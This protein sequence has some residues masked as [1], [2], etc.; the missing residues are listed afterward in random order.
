MALLT[1]LVVQSCRNWEALKIIC[2]FDISDGPDAHFRTRLR[3]LYALVYPKIRLVNSCQ[4]S[5]Y[6]EKQFEYK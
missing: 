4:G 5:K 2:L 1:P 6:L 3:V